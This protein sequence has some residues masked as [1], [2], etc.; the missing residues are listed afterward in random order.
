MGCS[1]AK[2]TSNTLHRITSTIA[3]RAL[4]DVTGGTWL[5]V[6]QRDLFG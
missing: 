6:Y 2:V 5:D 1:G 4:Q 3:Q